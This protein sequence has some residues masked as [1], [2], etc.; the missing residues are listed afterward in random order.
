M[1]ER[2]A[3]ASPETRP[4]WAVILRTQQHRRPRGPSGPWGISII[5][6][7]MLNSLGELVDLELGK[8]EARLTVDLRRRG[9]RLTR[10]GEVEVLGLVH[11]YLAAWLSRADDGIVAAPGEWP[12]VSYWYR[13]GRL[14]LPVLREEARAFGSALTRLLAAPGVIADGYVGKGRTRG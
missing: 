12:S 4:F 10:Q 11:Y 1:S 7:T 3:S 8:E 9:K 6:M 14:S 5:S 2:W 13:N